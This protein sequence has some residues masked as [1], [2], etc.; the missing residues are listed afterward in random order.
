MF[1]KTLLS[2]ITLTLPLT[3]LAGSDP[4]PTPTPD[5]GNGGS[6]E[7]GP[8]PTT[9]ALEA[10]RGP[11]SVGTINVSRYVSGF[12]GGTI[13]YPTN[14]SGSMGLIA[15]VPGFVSYESSIKWWGPRLAS[16]GFVVITIDTNSGYDQPD[17]RAEQLEAALNYTVSKSNDSG[18]AIHGM[19][20]ASRRG[21]IGWSMGGGG[22]LKLASDD[23]T[24]KAIIPQAPYYSGFNDFDEITTPT[25]IIA[26][27]SDTIAPVGSHASPFYYDV[28]NSTAKAF[29]EINNGSHYCA[30]SGNS[31]E[32][33]LG[34]L[35]VAW[36]KR[37]IDEDTR[38]DQF[39]CDGPDYEDD[40][41]VS[42]YRNSCR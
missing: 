30:N 32:D 22:T 23:H 20:D 41:S 18:S 4:E 36:M 42:D 27:E 31:D 40:R 34:K 21:V 37:Y 13:H 10:D 3:V 24:I 35:G 1:K 8:D 25:F 6:Y 29:L 16:H 12:G 2:L 28:P 19:V 26:C 33:L 11:Y 7:R 14:T 15:V 17:S 38:Y 39:L 9:S 5:P